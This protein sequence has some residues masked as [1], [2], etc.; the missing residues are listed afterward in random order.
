MRTPILIFSLCLC[1]TML[2]AQASGLRGAAQEAPQIP[3]LPPPDPGT[4]ERVITVEAVAEVRVRPTRLRLVF[5][6]S[7]AGESATAASVAGRTLLDETK[8]RLQQSGKALGELD[9]DFVAAVPIFSWRVEQQNGKDVLAERRS[10]TRV[11]YNLHV[12]VADEAAAL[13]AIEA[14]MAADGIDLL[15]VDYWS[16]D[17]AQK[18]VEA[19][20]QALATA[21]QKAQLL[22]SVF[23]V[24]PQPINVHEQTQVLFPQQLYQNIAR[25]EDS[26]A[27]WYSRDEM[28]RVPAS[29]PLL[30]YYRG[31]FGDLD[32]MEA[33]MPG[34]RDI[35]VVSTVRLYYKAPGA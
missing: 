4:A 7:A 1:A 26:A 24:A 20:E 32:A 27:N 23:P 5:A 21:R 28:P 30:V 12:E 31:L 29:R 9:V 3:R 2:P 15:A 10:G 17:L 35:E 8:A 25:A 34:K 13:V 11:Q 19:R 6:V 22:L 14:A 33:V 16:E 18:R